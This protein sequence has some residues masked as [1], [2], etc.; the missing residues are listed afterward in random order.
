MQKSE[1][2]TVKSPF[3]KEPLRIALINPSFEPSYWGQDYMLSVLS[4]DRTCNMV[5]GALPALAAL[6]E[7]PHTVELIDENVEELDFD[8]LG[9]FDIVGVTGMIV[10]RGRMYEIL[11]KLAPLPCTVIVGGSYASVSPEEFTSHCDVVFEGEADTTFPEYIDA[12]ACGALT[13]AHYKQA[14]P[15]DMTKVPKPRYD[16]LKQGRYYSAALQFSRGCPFRCEF[17]DII[18]IFGRRPRLKS[19]EKFLTELDE[20]H[21]HGFKVCFL[22]DDNFIAHKSKAKEL[23]VEIIKWQE[24]NDYPILLSTE[25]SLDVADDPEFLDLMV[26]ANFSSVF[27]G[28]ESPREESLKETLKLQNIRKGTTED[29][30]QRVRDAGLMITAGFIVGFDSD[31]DKIFEEQFDFVSRIAVAKAAIALLTPIP[32]TP[33][34]S[35][36]KSE[37]RLHSYGR[38]LHF[39]PKQIAP[40]ALTDG[41]Q[42][43]R[44]DLYAPDAYFQR[45]FDSIVTSPRYRAARLQIEKR[46]KSSTA[47]ATA[48]VSPQQIKRISKRFLKDIKRLQ[49]DVD[50]FAAYKCQWRKNRSLAPDCQLSFPA[51]LSACMNHWHYYL[52]AQDDTMDYVGH[53][54]PQQVPAM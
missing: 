12:L 46:A 39:T 28:L 4:D 31:D 37:D 27:I 51:F 14:T 22:V 35:R 45:V 48:Q 13:K 9:D 34:Y 1:R 3:V 15:T 29:K 10:Q 18:T 41:Y 11:A 33:L 42:K 52:I 24:T 8:V 38:G 19:P 23:L 5:T 44:Q 47:A 50:M 16:L 25:A 7:A 17:C 30:I 6:V 36:L 26:K 32:T 43:L 40:Q 53:A 54:E 49:G 21:A 2:Q 20:I